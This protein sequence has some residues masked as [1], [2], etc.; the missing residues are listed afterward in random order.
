[1]SP[2]RQP[3]AGRARMAGRGEVVLPAANRHARPARV[4]HLRR[5]WGQWAKRRIFFPN[6]TAT[7]A[8]RTVDGLEAFAALY[9]PHVVAAGDHFVALAVHRL[10]GLRAL[11]VP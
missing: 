5:Y 4:L 2:A 3:A 6:S 8:S 1:M 7:W 9:I 11:F 10:D